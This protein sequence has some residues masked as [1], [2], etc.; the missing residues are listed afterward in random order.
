MEIKMTKDLILFTEEE[1]P[2]VKRKTE[3]GL[4]LPSGLT[5]T[6]ETGQVEQMTQIVGFGIVK[7]VG[8]GCMNVQV[9]DGIFYDRRSLRPV[10]FKEAYWQ[11]NEGGIMGYVQDNDGELAGLIKQRKEEEKQEAKELAKAANISIVN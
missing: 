11:I 10:P 7:V 9:G 3:S 2:F 4:F 5:E 1:N 6:N 8:P